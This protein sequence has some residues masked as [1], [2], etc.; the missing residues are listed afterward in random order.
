MAAD[1]DTSTAEGIAS[2]CS[3]TS[4][5][6][7]RLNSQW[8]SCCTNAEYNGDEDKALYTYDKLATREAAKFDDR[9]DSG[10][11]DMALKAAGIGGE[12]SAEPTAVVVCALGCLPG[13]RMDALKVKSSQGDARM[14]KDALEELSAGGSDEVLAFE[15]FWVP[16]DDGTLD[17]D[18]LFVDWPE[19]IRC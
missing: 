18:E 4:L 16:G 13:D 14:A 9:D 5:L 19:L 17:M 8:I 3:D 10:T 1:A 12:K 7:L 2:L 15:L 11:V 6:L